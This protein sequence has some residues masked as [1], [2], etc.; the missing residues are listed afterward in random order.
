M[1]PVGCGMIVTM[2]IDRWFLVPGWQTPAGEIG[3]SGCV[4]GEFIAAVIAATGT[5][6]PAPSETDPLPVQ[7][8]PGWTPVSDGDTICGR[9]RTRV[10]AG[11]VQRAR[12]DALLRRGLDSD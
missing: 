11:A 9:C 8:P 1:L 4:T 6:P 3:C 5:P 2:L 7:A 10:G 12:T